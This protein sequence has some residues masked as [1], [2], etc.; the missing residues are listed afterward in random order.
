MFLKYHLFLLFYW[1]WIEKS[2]HHLP[3]SRLIVLPFAL[4]PLNG[5]FCSLFQ[6]STLYVIAFL[7]CLH[8]LWARNRWQ[9]SSFYENGATS[10]IF[11]HVCI[12]MCLLACFY[13]LVVLE[14]SGQSDAARHQPA[15][16]NC[17]GTQGSAVRPA[18]GQ[19]WQHGCEINFNHVERLQIT[20]TRLIH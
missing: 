2:Q 5:L 1:K 17:E 18:R 16:L 3:C 14:V 4:L 11:V 6:L 12:F 10:N 9:D 20:M 15:L 8:H 13:F 19:E 7:F